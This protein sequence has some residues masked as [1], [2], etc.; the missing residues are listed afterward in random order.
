MLNFKFNLNFTS[1]KKG[2][3][4]IF[5]LTKLLLFS[6]VSG[7]QIQTYEDF[8]YLVFYSHITQLY[9]LCLP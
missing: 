7:I 4:L 1:V 5:K 6:N 3:T 9:L 2:K 8:Y